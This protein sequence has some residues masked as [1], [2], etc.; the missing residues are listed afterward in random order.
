VCLPNSWP[1]DFQSDP[2]RKPLLCY[3]T[4]RRSLPAGPHKNF[5]DPLLD[6]IELVAAA[7][8]DW[9]QV[10]EKDLSGKQSAAL[11]R[12]ALLR[13]SR[14]ASRPQT[15]T[16][17]LIND[18]LDVALAEQAGGVHLGENSLPVQEA[19]RLLLTS[20]AAKS[21]PRDFLLGV[22]CHSLQSAQSAASAGADYIFFGPIFAT[23]SKAA[24]G[25]PQGLN[26][27]TEVCHS[28]PI[29]VLAI[30]GI[31]LENAPQCLSA[32]ASGIAAIRLFQDSADPARLVRALRRQNL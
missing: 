23:P 29:P 8:V 11:T 13:V 18:R 7:G 28:L 31:T 24:Y 10:R 19:R 21:P 5:L 12:E 2:E 9:I 30:G 1:L 22:S 32:G 27:L 6:K 17:I 14:H 15:V 16:R 3:V 26:R 4:G 25:A 20:H